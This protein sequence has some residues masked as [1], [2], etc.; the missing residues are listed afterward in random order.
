MGTIYV[1]VHACV[2]TQTLVASGEVHI[3]HVIV[4]TYYASIQLGRDLMLMT[5]ILLGA[6][7]FHCTSNYSAS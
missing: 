6:K 3:H 1:L 4:Q 2:Q 7:P 5:D